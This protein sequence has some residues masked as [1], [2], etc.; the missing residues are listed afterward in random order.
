MIYY[1]IGN[2]MTLQVQ[3]ISKIN[4]L[5]LDLL[6]EVNNY[7]DFLVSKYR[8]TPK[9]GESNLAEIDMSEYLNNLNEYE[10]LLAE[11]KIKW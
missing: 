8:I 3:T 9:N 2:I 1:S 4:S 11:G 7:I 6:T 5:P 10:N